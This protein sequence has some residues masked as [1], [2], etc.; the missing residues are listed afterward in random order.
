MNIETT[1]LALVLLAT[2]MLFGLGMFAFRLG[3]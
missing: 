3:G 2:L 1:I